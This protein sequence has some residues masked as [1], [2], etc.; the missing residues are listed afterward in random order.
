MSSLFLLSE[1]HAARLADARAI[2]EI[3][4]T[5]ARDVGVTAQTHAHAPRRHTGA[6]TITLHLPVEFA[7]EQ[8]PA[9]CLAC[10]LACFCSDSRVSVLV[11][12]EAAFQRVL[13]HQHIVRVL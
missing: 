10:R 6:A 3:V 12:S 1:I 5:C 11:H 7:A 13:R 2:A 4:T 8:H 9:W